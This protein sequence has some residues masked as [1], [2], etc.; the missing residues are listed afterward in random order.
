MSVSACILNTSFLEPQLGLFRSTRSINKNNT[1]FD[2]SRRSSHAAFDSVA[3]DLPPLLACI[4]WLLSKQGAAGVGEHC[5]TLARVGN[6]GARPGCCS[7]VFIVSYS[8]CFRVD[9]L[10]G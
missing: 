7:G 10:G 4:I 1:S 2:D 3:Y 6:P 8:H 5:E 9:R